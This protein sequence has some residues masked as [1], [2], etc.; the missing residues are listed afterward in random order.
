MTDLPR[1]ICENALHGTSEKTFDLFGG[2]IYAV[3][4]I[5]RQL[6]TVRLLFLQALKFL[7]VSPDYLSADFQCRV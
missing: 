6:Q 7:G 1:Y 2:A 3:P 5:P 4:D